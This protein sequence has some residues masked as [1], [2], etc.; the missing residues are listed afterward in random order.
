MK[1]AQ[2]SIS[3]N[4]APADKFGS[5]ADL[6]NTLSRWVALG[7]GFL[8]IA[9]FVYTA[10]LYMS[11]NGDTK[12]IEKAKIVITY[13]LIGMVVIAASYWITQIIAKF[14]GQNF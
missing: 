10:Y 3:D 1:L 9:A 11:S 8:V 6:V 12:T 7:G 5:I 14:L 13:S 4:F 2:V